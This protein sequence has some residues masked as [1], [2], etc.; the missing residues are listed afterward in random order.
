MTS[1]VLA[2]SM[3]MLILTAASAP[4]LA[5]PPSISSGFYALTATIHGGTC[6]ADQLLPAF[7]YLLADGKPASFYYLGSP[8]S[9]AELVNVPPPTVRNHPRWHGH[10][11]WT[12]NPF[13]FQPPE[14][15]TDFDLTT[16]EPAPGIIFLNGEM[17]VPTKE[18]GTC[19]EVVAYTGVFY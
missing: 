19:T 4:A 8:G 3:A 9:G 6:T 16:S 10:M 17:T 7:S 13:T 14:V 12:L 1:N 18:G 11:K 2:R 15:I 5:H